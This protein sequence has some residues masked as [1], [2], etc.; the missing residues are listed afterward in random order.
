MEGVI[1]DLDG[2]LLDS[3]G[4]WRRAGVIYLERYGIE[5]D[6]SLADIILPLTIRGAARYIKFL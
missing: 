3:M 2:T 1:F 5:V 4:L 6:E